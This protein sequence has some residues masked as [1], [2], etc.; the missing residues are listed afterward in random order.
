MSSDLKWGG[1]RE[2]SFSKVACPIFKRKNGAGKPII[3]NGLVWLTNWQ[4]TNSNR[5]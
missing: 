2:A 5:S 4:F 1:E 3:R